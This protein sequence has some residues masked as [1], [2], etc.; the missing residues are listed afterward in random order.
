[1]AFA[2]SEKSVTQLVETARDVLNARNSIHAVN[3]AI[4]KGLI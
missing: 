2:T 1:M 4:R 3:I